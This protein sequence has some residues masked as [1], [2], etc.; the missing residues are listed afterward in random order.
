MKKS[1]EEC[2]GALQKFKHAEDPASVYCYRK[3]CCTSKLDSDYI[4]SDLCHCVI[5]ACLLLEC[6][7]HFLYMPAYSFIAEKNDTM[8]QPYKVSLSSSVCLPWDVVA[9]SYCHTAVFIAGCFSFRVTAQCHVLQIAKQWTVNNDYGASQIFQ[10]NAMCFIQP[11]AFSSG[12]LKCY[13]N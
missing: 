5:V 11:L 12:A 9:G 3:K 4:K 1:S 10:V 8:V 2:D 6:L 13:I 7:L